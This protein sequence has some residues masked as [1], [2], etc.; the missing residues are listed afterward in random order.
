MCIGSAVF[1][2]LISLRKTIKPR[3]LIIL[4][5]TACV[6]LLSLDAMLANRSHGAIEF[7][8]SLNEFQH[9]RVDDNFLRFAQNIEIV[10][11]FQPHTGL[12]WLIWVL[13]RPVPRVFW[14]GKPTGPGFDLSS[15]LGITASLSCSSIAEWYVA[16][17]WG[18][19][20]AA[21]VLYGKLCSFWGQLLDYE[22]QLAGI[23]MYGLGIL[24][25]FISMRSM[26]EL[27]LMSYPLLAW[28]LMGSQITKRGYV[29]AS[30]GINA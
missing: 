26:I 9:V 23:G 15:Y 30:T 25:L 27:I 16:F 2:W 17:G 22:L 21:G 6:L 24:A 1:S 7:S 12:Q 28:L 14:P 3:H 18:G 13:A 20:I 29:S 4:L 10:P 11:R 19:V 8:Y 5:V